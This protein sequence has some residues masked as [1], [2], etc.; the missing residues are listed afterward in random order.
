MIKKLL[1]TLLMCVSTVAFAE[2]SV[3][4]KNYIVPILQ[5]QPMLAR[6][7]LES[8]TVVGDPMGVRIG[9]EAIPGLGGGRIGPYRVN[10]IWHSTKGDV[11]AVLVINTIPTFFDKD[12]HLLGDDDRTAMKVTEAVDSISLEPSSGE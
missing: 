3:S 2:G 8:F 11:P 6:F 7:V 5:K 1:A 12:G 4:F 10:V 9:D